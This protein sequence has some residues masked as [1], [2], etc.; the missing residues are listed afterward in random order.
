MLFR[1]ELEDFYSIRDRQI[2]DLRLPENAPELPHRFTPIHAE[3]KER[4]PKIVAIFG[5]NASGKSMAL[6]GLSFLAWF[7]QHSFLQLPAAS[8]TPPPGIGFQP[9]ERFYANDTSEQLTR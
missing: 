1:L 5:P 6:R 2:I 4:A 7:V 9:C 8:D 3:S